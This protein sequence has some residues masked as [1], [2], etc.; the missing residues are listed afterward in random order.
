MLGDTQTPTRPAKPATGP[1][2]ILGPLNDGFADAFAEL[3]VRG[4]FVDAGAVARARRASDAT[5]ER[6][7]V[8]M[9]KLGL[10]SEADL[11]AAYADYCGLPVVRPADIPLQPVLPDRLKLPFLKASR[12]LP[13][14]VAGDSLVLA[15]VDPL[16]EEARKAISYMLGCRVDL[17][18]IAPADMERAFRKLYQDTAPQ[19]VD[20]DPNA[21]VA[22]QLDGNEID[23]ERLRDIANEAPI[24]RLVNQI[25]ASAVERGASDIHIEPGRDAVL[26]RFRLDGFLQQERVV[27]PTLKAA[28]TTRI[29]IMA[30]LDIAERR[31]PQDGRIK[32][33]V[34]GVEIDIRVAT[35]PTAF[36]ESLVLR[37]LDRTRVELDFGKLGLDPAV[38]AGLHGLMS[39]PNGIILVTGPTGSGKTTTLYTALKELN[40]PELKLFTVEDPIEYQLGGINQVQVQPQ[41]GFDF[42]AALRSILR[43]DPDIIMIGEIRDLETARIAVQASLTGHLVFSTLHTNSSVA[44][45]TRLIDIGIERYLLASTVAGVMAQRL[46]RRL[47]PSCARPA[48]YRT[49]AP[50]RLRW[51]V[52]DTLELDW[53][54][55]REAVGCAACHGTGYLGRTCVVELLVIDDEMREAIGRRSDDQRALMSRARDAGFR[56]LYESGLVKVTQGETTIEEVLRVSRTS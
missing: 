19:S 44:A 52:P 33:A 28:L 13:I 38:Q 5:S 36:G 20:G 43:Q 37:I 10:I 49:V 39:L 1:A 40:R 14:S 46:V 17:A 12:A 51:P 50:S 31:L 18:V 54:G 23:V 8:V 24:I 53:S 2:K 22:G 6:L 42:P 26:V 47:C 34:R 21:I 35:L 25:I 48:S 16:D 32:T 4:E 7:D 55:A 15:A 27:P 56:S 3:L 11:C 41:I 29:K 30:R 45:I 9:V